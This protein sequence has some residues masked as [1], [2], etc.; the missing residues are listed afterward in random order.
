M[1]M[2]KKGVTIIGAIFLYHIFDEITDLEENP[3]QQQ[4]SDLKE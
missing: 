2:K 1:I 4:S 3:P